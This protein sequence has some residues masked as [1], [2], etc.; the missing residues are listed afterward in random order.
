MTKIEIAHKKFIDE[1]KTKNRSDATIVA[2]TK[3][4]EQLMSHLITQGVDTTD[5]I[6]LIHVEAF[7]KKLEGQ[8]YSAKS[9]SR[10]TNAARTFLKYLHAKG[11]M[12]LNIAD[13]L[14]HPKLD[15]LTPRVLS[16]LEYRA[17]RD[18][19]KNDS[20]AY[21]VIE[22]LLQ[23]GITISELA[24]I[25]NSRV[26]LRNDGGTIFI[27]KKNGREARNVPLNKV[28][29]ETI[30]KYLNVDKV[31]TDKSNYLFVTKSGQGMLVRNIRSTVDRY[32]RAA[33]IKGAKVNDLRHTFVVHHLSAGVNVNY[34]SKILG[35]KRVSTTERYLKYAERV[36]GVAEKFELSII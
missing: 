27:P 8:N 18:A 36:E 14:K 12:E 19:A 11:H 13:K 4:L 25:E 21:A 1:L 35:H 7:M 3:D 23:T 15:S 2:Y 20:R 17:L 32:F 22:T 28:A 26:E 34:L 24:E 10:K 5:K 31:A 29:V 30:K 9:I 16:K 33:G 6:E